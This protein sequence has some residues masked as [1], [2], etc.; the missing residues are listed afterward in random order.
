MKLLLA[1]LLAC[2]L[3]GYLTDLGGSSIWVAN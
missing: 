1:S 3:A 2:A